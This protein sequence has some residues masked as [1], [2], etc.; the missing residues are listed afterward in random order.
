M[1]PIPKAVRAQIKSRACLRCDKAF[2][3]WG[4]DH[5]LCQT[6]R[7]HLSGEPTPEEPYEVHIH[8]GSHEN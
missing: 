1:P 6:C 2:L 7:E 8:L 5:R 4:A 3:S